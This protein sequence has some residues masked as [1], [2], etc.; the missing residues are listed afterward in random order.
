MAGF[1]IAYES[2]RDE[3]KEVTRL[4]LDENP[5]VSVY[6]TGHSMGGSLAVLA[7][8]D[9][10]VNFSMKVNMYNFGGPR[11]GNPSFRRHYDKCV[12][13][14]Y[15][16]VMDGDIVPGVP[17]FVEFL[18]G[19]GVHIDTPGK[20]GFVKLTRA[21][22]TLTIGTG[23][24]AL[25]AAAFQEHGK[26]VRVLLANEA[27]PRVADTEGRTPVDYASI[28][29]AIWPFFAGT[30]KVTR[31]LPCLAN[32][33]VMSVAF[34]LLAGMGIARGGHKSLKSELVA[35]G[36]IR[37]LPDQPEQTSS[38]DKYADSVRT[39]F[40]CSCYCN[41]HRFLTRAVFSSLDLVVLPTWIRVYQGAIPAA[42][43]PATKPSAQ[44]T[45]CIVDSSCFLNWGPTL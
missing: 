40:M 43:R 41:L 13:T 44:G 38:S 32:A 10:A 9:L 23:W 26:V 27:D 19:N 14:S 21:W 20:E 15:R 39:H 42:T 36:I 24:T 33:H 29:E 8:Y 22:M 16:V 11:V 4:I 37:K 18:L 6:V 25:H 35:K 45:Q 7:A 5:G 2:I 12:P 30:M 28:S 3:L 17:R 31:D 34:A 1:W